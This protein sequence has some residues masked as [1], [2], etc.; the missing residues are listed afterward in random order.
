M[1]VQDALALKEQGNKRF[2]KGDYAS[3]EGLYSQA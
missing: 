1:A 3:A 2:A